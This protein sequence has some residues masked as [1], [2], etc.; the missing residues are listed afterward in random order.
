MNIFST[1]TGQTEPKKNATTI[2]TAKTHWQQKRSQKWVKR[3]CWNQVFDIYSF[4]HTNVRRLHK[5]HTRTHTCIRHNLKKY[6][7]KTEMEVRTY[8]QT[9]MQS[10]WNNKLN[11]ICIKSIKLFCRA[12][13]QK[14]KE[15]KKTKTKTKKTF[16]QLK[17][18]IKHRHKMWCDIEWRWNKKKRKE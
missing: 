1:G 14:K 17:I 6:F 8:T 18:S 2:T 10:Y 9:N 13:I 5:S 3:E 12:R 16:L 11:K 4:I 7:Y 15:I